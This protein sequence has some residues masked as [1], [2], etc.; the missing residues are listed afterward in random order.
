MPEYHGI[1]G[2]IPGSRASIMLDI[3]FLAMFAVIPVMAWS[4]YLVRYKANYLLHKRI[5]LGLG[6]VLLI[7]VTLFEIDMRFVS[8]WRDRAELSPY[9]GQ[10]GGWGTVDYSLFVHLFFAVSTAVLW[11][12]VIFRAWKK[13]PNPPGPNEHSREHM[14]WARLAA[15]DMFCTAVTG[16]IF[17]W[18]AFMAT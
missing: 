18:L 7:A 9:A 16:W 10:D 11:V 15:I 17:Y 3:V 8:G 13:F 6:L 12:V 5:Q 2:F 1:N 4:I 14:F